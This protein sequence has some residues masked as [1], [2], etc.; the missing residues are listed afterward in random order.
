M[1][2][3]QAPIH[4]LYFPFH[5][6]WEEAFAHTADPWLFSP[7]PI[8]REMLPAKESGSRARR[9]GEAGA[10]GAERISYSSSPPAA[11]PAKPP[12]PERQPPKAVPA[13]TWSIRVLP[14]AFL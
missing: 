5:S 12:S 11:R 3:G 2:P 9:R 14:D 13:E 7:A 10:E 6:P 8:S 4:S 1:E